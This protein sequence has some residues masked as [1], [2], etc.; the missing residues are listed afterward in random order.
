MR[1]EVFCAGALFWSFMGPRVAVN[2]NGANHQIPS[3][4]SHHGQCFYRKQLE[5]YADARYF[6]GARLGEVRGI[7]I[8]HL[9]ALPKYVLALFP[10]RK[11][12]LE[13]AEL[14][15]PSA[16]YGFVSDPSSV[17]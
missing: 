1:T 12:S 5:D 14:N 7:R 10:E 8:A 17:S 16:D 2:S 4:T 15:A 6:Q 13:S 9:A 3:R 11:S